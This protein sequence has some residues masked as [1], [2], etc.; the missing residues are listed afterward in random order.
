[1]AVQQHAIA[2]LSAGGR[3]LRDEVTRPNT[4]QGES[5]LCWPPL[6]ALNAEFRPTVRTSDA[7]QALA[8]SDA[9]MP[10]N[11]WQPFIFKAKIILLY[12]TYFH[13]P[14]MYRL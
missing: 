4:W 2:E 5:F 3:G 10:K 12:K 6:A 1:M 8:Y 13:G 11:G 14:F 9:Y 7:D